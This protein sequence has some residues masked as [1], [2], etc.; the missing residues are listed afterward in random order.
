MLG[1]R[2]KTAQVGPQGRFSE[3]FG[4][5]LTCFGVF[6]GF[7]GANRRVSIRKSRLETHAQQSSTELV[8]I[9]WR[10]SYSAP[11]VVSVA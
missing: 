4:R 8:S 1:L 2:F 11:K 5:S 9:H 6:L 3:D 10:K 7:Y